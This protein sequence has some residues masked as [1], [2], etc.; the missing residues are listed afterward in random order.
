[1][2]AYLR[3]I[4]QSRRFLYIVLALIVFAAV[5][6][7]LET[8]PKIEARY[9]PLLDALNNIVLWAF[10][11]EALIKAGQHGWRFYRYF[12]DPWNV[13]DFAI[14]AVCFLPIDGHY[15]AVMRLARIFRALRLITAIP[16]LQILVNALLKSIPSMGYVGLLLFLLFYVYGVMGVFLFR[17]NDPMRFGDLPNAM[18][19]L[20]TVVTQEGWNEVLYIQMFGSDV[21]TT[22]NPNNMARKSVPQPLISAIFFITFIFLGTMILLNLFIGVIL[23]S[24]EEVQQQANKE[25]AAA[26]PPPGESNTP[27]ESGTATENWQRFASRFDELDSRLDRL[28]NL[29]VNHKPMADQGAG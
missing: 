13:F 29:I 3:S 8:N 16:R 19:T 14:I 11:V 7:G 4:A 20:F 6:V 18:L 5:L 24:M 27:D 26:L 9:R 17:E 21:F 25:R 2:S 22:P 28:Q 15:V 23:N 10:V 12:Y 1:M